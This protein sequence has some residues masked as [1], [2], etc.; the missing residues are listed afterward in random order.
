M[1]ISIYLLRFLSS[2]D[3]NADRFFI[4]KRIKNELVIMAI[5]LFWVIQPYPAV[6]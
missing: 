5:V 2:N 1:A 3:I 6:F 4:M